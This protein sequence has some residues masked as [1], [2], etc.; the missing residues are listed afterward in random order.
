MYNFFL[1]SNGRLSSSYV[2]SPF[3]PVSVGIYLRHLKD[4]FCICTGRLLS[5]PSVPPSPFSSFFSWV[6]FLNPLG[7]PSRSSGATTI[8][9]LRVLTGEG[10][11]RH[12]W[13]VVKLNLNRK[14]PHTDVPRLHN[15]PP[16]HI[17]QGNRQCKERHLII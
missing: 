7:A 10:R 4:F 2:G 1:T 17:G 15:R 11:V 14:T 5:N 12:E 9:D 16:V 3:D 6:R 13:F 8:C